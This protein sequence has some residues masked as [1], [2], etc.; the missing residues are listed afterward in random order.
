MVPSRSINII[1]FLCTSEKGVG[2][3]RR[4]SR[5]ECIAHS[6]QSSIFLVSHPSKSLP[7]SCLACFLTKIPVLRLRFKKI[8]VRTRCQIWKG[9]F[10][11]SAKCDGVRCSKC[12]SSFLLAHEPKKV[13]G[14]K[15]KLQE[16]RGQR[17]DLISTLFF[18]S[19]GE[20]RRK[21]CADCRLKTMLLT[22]GRRTLSLKIVWLVFV[23]GCAKNSFAFRLC[24]VITLLC[25]SAE[26]FAVWT[27]QSTRHS[28][29]RRGSDTCSGCYSI[30]STEMCQYSWMSQTSFK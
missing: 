25:P 19:S 16:T 20:Q 14:K 1:F 27:N 8:L 9:H 13:W 7:R 21:S 24:D 12:D 26:P 3:H 6:D 23:K 22:T 5:K 28:C 30:W 29:S 17:S 4:K 18:L 15:L 10:C 2:I 11:T